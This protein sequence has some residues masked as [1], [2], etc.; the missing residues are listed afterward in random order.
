MNSNFKDP[1]LE[2]DALDKD[3]WHLPLDWNEE[4]SL[5]EYLNSLGKTNK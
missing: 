5:E 1:F 4:L 2:E 3:E